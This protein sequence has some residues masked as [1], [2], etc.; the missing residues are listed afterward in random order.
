MNE[1]VIKRKNFFSLKT[2]FFSKLINKFTWMNWHSKLCSSSSLIHSHFSEI[3]FVNVTKN[4]FMVKEYCDLG[5]KN[6][7]LNWAD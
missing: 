2:F 6:W 1:C 4:F 7:M 5:K 3:H